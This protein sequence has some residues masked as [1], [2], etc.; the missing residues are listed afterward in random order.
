M[1]LT[2]CELP[3]PTEPATNLDEYRRRYSYLFVEDSTKPLQSYTMPTTQ[4]MI[5]SLPVSPFIGKP[6]D[7]IFRIWEGVIEP[8]TEC[9]SLIATHCFVILDTRTAKGSNTVLVVTPSINK[10]EGR[11]YDGYTFRRVSL[12]ALG[13]GLLKGLEM[14]MVDLRML[15]VVDDGVVVG[16]AWGWESTTEEDDAADEQQEDVEDAAQVDSVKKEDQ[17]QKDGSGKKSDKQE[18][19]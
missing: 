13:K 2:T 5:G 15:E 18:D 6:I 8:V 14:L 9:R 10:H 17:E 11:F 4:E 19:V 1:F 12:R 7:D 16:S 3:P